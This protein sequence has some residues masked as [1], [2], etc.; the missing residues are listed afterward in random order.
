MEQRC[1]LIQSLTFKCSLSTARGWC[2]RTGIGMSF[3]RTIS[4]KPSRDENL[5]LGGGENRRY[6]SPSGVVISCSS[7][8]N[9]CAFVHACTASQSTHASSTVLFAN[10]TPGLSAFHAIARTPRSGWQTNLLRSVSMQ[11]SMCGGNHFASCAVALSP[12]A[13]RQP[14]PATWWRIESRQCRWW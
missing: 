4:T 8:E 3:E 12:S 1:S 6:F 9:E 7:A 2:M 5:L 11:W 14:S 13:A 10:A